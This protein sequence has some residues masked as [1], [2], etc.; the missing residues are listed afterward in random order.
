VTYSD[1]EFDARDGIGSSKPNIIVWLAAGFAVW[2]IATVGLGWFG[3]IFLERGLVV[4]VASSLA[5][6]GA[7][8]ALFEIFTRIAKISNFSFLTAAVSFSISGMFGEVI[9]F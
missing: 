1:N 7:F 3:D 4:Y 5:L 8:I 6:T 2:L 9:F